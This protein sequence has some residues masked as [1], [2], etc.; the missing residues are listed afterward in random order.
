MHENDISMH[1]NEKLVFMDKCAVSNFMHG[2]LINEKFGAKLSFTRIKVSFSCMIF[3]YD[4]FM[5]ETFRTGKG[6]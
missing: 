5:H 6:Y 2:I 4:L 1:E 3:C